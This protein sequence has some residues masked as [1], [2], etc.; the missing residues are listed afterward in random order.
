MA[1]ELPPNGTGQVVDTFTTVAGKERQVTIRPQGGQFS[2]FNAP[3]A[4]TQATVS[5]AAGAAGVINVA[6]NISFCISTV[7]TAQT[8]LSI[9]LRNGATGAGTV[10]WTKQFILPVNSTLS[11]N[12]PLPDIQG[13]AA[14]AMT[15]EFSGAGVAASVQSVSL[16]GYTTA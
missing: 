7:G 2:L 11:E 1:V 5:Q 15:L 9:N 6:T 14:T 10:L 8:V 12:I 16:Q 3:A 13:S 4:A